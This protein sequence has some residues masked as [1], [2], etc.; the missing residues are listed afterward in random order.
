MSCLILSF[1]NCIAID[2]ESEEK[3]NYRVVSKDVCLELKANEKDG[4]VVAR[5]FLKCRSAMYGG[6]FGFGLR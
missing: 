3:T 6:G 5:M 1:L 4:S 2:M